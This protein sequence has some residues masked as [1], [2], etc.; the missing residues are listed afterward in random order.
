MR[1][2][3]VG[4]M[5]ILAG[6]CAWCIEPTGQALAREVRDAT[7]DPAACYRVRELNFNKED[8]KFYLTDGFLIFARPV[9]GRRLFAVFS[10]EVE[11]GDAEVLL[12]P[13]HRSE[14]RSLA[15]FSGAPNLDEHFKTALFLFSDQLG[16]ELFARA[17]ESGR[18]SAEMGAHMTERWTSLAQN[19][20]G[21]FEVRMVQDLLSPDPNAGV[22]FAGIAG[23]K[24]GNFD[25]YFDP[26][27]REQIFVGQF[28]TR[29]G[30]P[31]FDV[32]TTFEARSTR[33]GR[34]KPPTQPVQMTRYRIQVDLD[35]AL[36]MKAVTRA[37][38]TTTLP[39]RAVGLQVSD[40]VNITAVSIDGKPAEIYKSESM[41]DSA[42]R[43][44]GN[45]VF[46]AIAADPISPGEP[47]EIEV[48]HE[49]DVVVPAGNEVYYVG[50]RGNWY[51]RC[52][53]DF[54]TYD[55]TFRYPKNL[56][57]VATGDVK[58]ERVDGEFK[59]SRNVT[60][61]PVRVAGFNLGRYEQVKLDRGGYTIQVF[62]NRSLEPNL[63]PKVPHMVM[64][65]QPRGTVS[66]GEV[67]A[68]PPPMPINPALRLSSVADNVGG[69]F[70]YL[71]SKFGPLAIKGLTVSP[72]PG[73]F[74]QGFPTL[75]YLSTISYLSREERPLRL[76]TKYDDIFFTDLL[77]AHEVAHQ[78]WGNSVFPAGY[79]DEWLMEALANYS[80]L[81]YL[82]KRK[83]TRALDEVLGMFESNLLQKTDEKRT[84]ESTGPITWGVRLQSSLSEGAW[85]TITYEKGAWIIHMLRR[86]LGDA[87]FQKLLAETCR[88]YAQKPLST[89]QFRKLAEEMMGAKAGSEPLADFFESWV[90][91]TGIPS[92]KVSWSL[93]GKA[94]AYRVSGTVEQSGVDPDFSVEVPIEIEFAKGPPTV[95][96]VRTSEDSVS[97]SVIVRKP[98]ARVVL[99]AGSDIL[100]IRK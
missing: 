46:V 42:F 54:A 14:R 25:V 62:G 39:L 91:G 61:L 32:W 50:S 96:W 89:D 64:L 37:E 4:A 57:L 68:P 73:A 77:A 28:T 8:V 27:S 75:V 66:H 36:H 12:M 9:H 47:H 83:G 16:D 78:W 1:F 41:R 85:R 84:V 70:D 55:L 40:R 34:S 22:F 97:F 76:R 81:M 45:A 30:H 100:A 38:L 79:Q 95:H 69:A 87:A 13:P 86:R 20:S 67:F 19:I 88:R 44:G 51:P 11:G 48:Q 82:E 56:T 71:R 26:Y 98:P 24:V 33:T 93:K 29:T 58:E 94:P 74:G 7:L 52:G 3:F 17:S 53:Q 80:A 65:P 15:T 59:I 2:W 92:L 99:P 6:G 5:A 63:Q 23:D 49:G 60:N 43:I 10:A 35:A 31:S 21:G 72:I 90:Y 18:P